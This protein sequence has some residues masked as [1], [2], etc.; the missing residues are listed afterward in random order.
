MVVWDCIFRF[1]TKNLIG[2]I[3]LSQVFK[4]GNTQCVFGRLQD[5]I[6]LS[7]FPKENGSVS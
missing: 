6:G 1:S 4:L 7:I 3:L 5:V 2:S